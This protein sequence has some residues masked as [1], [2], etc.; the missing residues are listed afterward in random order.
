MKKLSVLFVIALLLPVL[1]GCQGTTNAPGNTT[2]A[3][4][5]VETTAPTET[6]APMD[7]TPPPE[8][9]TPVAQELSGETEDLIGREKAKKIALDDAKV[10]ESE[11]RDLDIE[12]DRDDG[13]IHYDVDFEVGGKDYDY[14]IDAKTGEILRSETPPKSSESS[15]DSSATDKLTAAEAR[16]IALKHAGLKKSEVRDLEVELDNDD[17]KTHYDVS[18]EKDNY[19]YDY[20]IDVASGKI[21][22]SEKERD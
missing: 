7:T 6:T 12:L 8:T 17:G 21:L 4:P 1:V 15:S 5:P 10:K 16:D 13:T 3:P 20:E 2:Q 19:D 11:I 18:F 14:E 9:T 22:K